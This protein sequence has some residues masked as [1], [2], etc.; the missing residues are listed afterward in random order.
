MAQMLK[1]DVPRRGHAARLTYCE[2]I[3]N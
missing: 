1:N 2:F 3:V